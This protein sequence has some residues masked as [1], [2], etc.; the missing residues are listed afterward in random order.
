MDEEK[1]KPKCPICRTP[2]DMRDQN[3][4]FP[5][6]SSHCQMH[7]L[8]NWINEEYRMPVGQHSTERMLPNDDDDLLN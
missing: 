1:K 5:F 6:C 8:G 4:F 3:R 2:V 7:D